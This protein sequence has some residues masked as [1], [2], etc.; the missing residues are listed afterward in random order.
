MSEIIPVVPDPYVFAMYQIFFK[1]DFSWARFWST[2]ISPDFT[3]TI[4]YLF[5]NCM[6]F[7]NQNSFTG[8][9]PMY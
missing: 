7:G 1:K 8:I 2:T 9:N 6:S 4:I 3:G 5:L